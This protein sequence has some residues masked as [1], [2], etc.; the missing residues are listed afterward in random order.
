MRTW[1]CWMIVLAAPGAHAE[2]FELKGTLACAQPS[3]AGSLVS[4]VFSATGIAG[5]ALSTDLADAKRFALV[6]DSS[7]SRISVVE[8]CDGAEHSL[9]AT[10]QSARSTMGAPSGGKTPYAITQ[11]L[12]MTDWDVDV[13]LGHVVCNF[14]GDLDSNTGAL[15][16]AKGTCT[17]ALT[18]T[19]GE[20]GY[21][22]FEAKFGKRLVIPND[23][24][25]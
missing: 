17:G 4:E 7:L 16:T 5:H 15:M 11:L 22:G 1:L 9:F 2:L 12:Q 18:I 10:N 13:E 3:A 8:R 20:Q 24:P 14:S 19:D 23:C 6:Y 21:C 25:T